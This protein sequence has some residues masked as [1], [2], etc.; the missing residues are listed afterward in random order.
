[1]PQPVG[2]SRWLLN[3][4]WKQWTENIP[5]RLRGFIR[6]WQKTVDVSCLIHWTFSNKNDDVVCW[7]V[8]LGKWSRAFLFSIGWKPDSHL[9]DHF[10]LLELVLQFPCQEMT[11]IVC[12][13]TLSAKW[14]QEI[15]VI[16]QKLKYLCY[17]WSHFIHLAVAEHVEWWS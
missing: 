15:T 1:M 4:L 7:G 3:F 16:Q 12:L 2:Q 14:A 10:G 6:P 17:H 8:H 9:T 13:K 11:H 5:N